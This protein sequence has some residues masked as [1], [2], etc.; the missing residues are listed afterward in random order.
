MA[1]PEEEES[2]NGEEKDGR[3]GKQAV[4]GREEDVEESRREPEPVPEPDVARLERTAVNKIARYESGE[5]TDQKNDGE[6]RVA[7]EK[8]RD[9]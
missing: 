4:I 7:E 2:E 3:P 1:A 5:Q 8:F 6:E 9:A